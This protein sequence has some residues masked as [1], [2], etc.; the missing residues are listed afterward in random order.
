[1]FPFT[2]GEHY[3]FIS[4]NQYVRQNSSKDINMHKRYAHF[5]VGVEARVI[6]SI[7]RE[8]LHENHSNLMQ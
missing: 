1:M 2:P 3:N 4:L 5:F 8:L 6:L 7:I